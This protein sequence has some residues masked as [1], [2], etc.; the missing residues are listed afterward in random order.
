MTVT[1]D[2][3]R[4]KRIGREAELLAD[5]LLDEGIDVGIGANRAA[6]GSGGGDLARL[7]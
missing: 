7:L 1:C 5:V 3:L 6:D 4:G 2:D